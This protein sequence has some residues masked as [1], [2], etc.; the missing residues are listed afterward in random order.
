MVTFKLDKEY[1]W[2]GIIL[3]IIAV[4]SIYWVPNI[5][6][7]VLFLYTLFYSLRTPYRM[8]ALEDESLV[9]YRVTGRET[10]LFSDII[11]LYQSPFGGKIR[12]KSGYIQ[13]NP[14]L[15]HI[16]R[17]KCMI[18]SHLSILDNQKNVPS[19]ESINFIKN[20]KLVLTFI[21]L[22]L[23]SILFPVLLYLSFLF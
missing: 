19:K 15:S 5:F 21:M 1:V 14:L 18:H 4:L 12:H 9:I 11:S 16:D 6:S 8:D 13:L 23:F 2:L 20:P 3:N 10:I 7:C 17:L 22:L